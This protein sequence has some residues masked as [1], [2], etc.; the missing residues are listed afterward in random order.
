MREHSISPTVR[1]LM[2][3]SPTTR[4]PRR[5]LRLVY[6][7]TVPP[8]SLHPNHPCLP[9]PYR[10]ICSIDTSCQTPRCLLP[11]LEKRMCSCLCSCWHTSP[12]TVVS[13]HTFK[14]AISCLGSR[15]VRS[16]LCLTEKRRFQRS[17]MTKM[18]MTKSTCYLMISTSSLWSKSSPCAITA[19]I[20]STGRVSS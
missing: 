8:W 13:D 14:R 7:R 17:S 16:W 5:F 18:P 9:R 3:V 2:G 6:H 15:L 11:C 20:C 12:S 10:D 1:R 4:P 19:P